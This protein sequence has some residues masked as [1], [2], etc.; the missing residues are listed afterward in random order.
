MTLPALIAPHKP[1]LSV[2]F[3]VPHLCRCRLHISCASALCLCRSLPRSLLLP[4]HALIFTNRHHLHPLRPYP[5]PSHVACLT[6]AELYLPELRALFRR[7]LWV[8]CSM[9]AITFV[10]ISIVWWL[11][12]Q[13]RRVS[14]CEHTHSLS[15]TAT[16]MFTH[17]PPLDSR[18]NAGLVSFK[19]SIIMHLLCST[20]FS[21][22]ASDPCFDSHFVCYSHLCV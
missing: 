16:L 1:Y 4:F 12:C 21:K 10:L 5:S 2:R 15:A 18:V 3:A 17:S 7:I 20:C 13:V 11:L 14:Q 22:F 19:T 9:A 6:G 8:T